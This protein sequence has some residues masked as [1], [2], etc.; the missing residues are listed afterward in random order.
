MRILNSRGLPT[1]HHDAHVPMPIHGPTFTKVFDGVDY[2]PPPGVTIHTM[3][4]NSAPIDR[5]D[6]GRRKATC[7]HPCH[8][9]HN[10]QRR[11]EGRTFLGYNDDGLTPALMAE[12]EGRFREPSPWEA[13][14]GATA[15]DCDSVRCAA[16]KEPTAPLPA[17]TPATLLY[18]FCPWRQR[19]EM[20]EF[21]IRCLGRYLRQFNKV[22]MSLI[23][24]EDFFPAEEMKARLLP[25]MRP[26]HQT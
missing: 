13:D 7:E 18:H 19:P 11:L 22:R 4:A 14:R 15:V 5:E 2:V 26:E 25:L 17:E 21:H 23:V 24:G 10:I 12:I 16:I 8:F 1:W 9:T 3:Y 6:L 20:V